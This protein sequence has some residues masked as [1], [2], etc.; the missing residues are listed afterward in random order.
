MISFKNILLPTDFSGNAKPAQDYA[1]ELT[2]QFDSRLHVLSVV[3]DAALVLPETGMFLTIPLPSIHEIIEAAESSLRDLLEPQWQ[4]SHDVCLK[5]AV[6]TPYVEIVRYAEENKIDLIV[7]GTHGRTGLQHVLLGSVAERVL[8][9][10]TC[11]VLTIRSAKPA[12]IT[13]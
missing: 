6:G 7:L 9:Q 8:R 5:V 4:S 11:P 1:C 2:D 13:P 10:A 12:E 3:Q